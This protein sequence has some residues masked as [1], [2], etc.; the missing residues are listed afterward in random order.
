MLGLHNEPCSMA[1]KQIPWAPNFSRLPMQ[2]IY[3]HT[4]YAHIFN[5]TVVDTNFLS[6]KFSAPFKVILKDACCKNVS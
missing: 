4:Q 5:S 6:D 1:Q 3:R 2:H